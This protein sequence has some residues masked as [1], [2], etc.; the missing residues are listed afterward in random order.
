MNRTGTFRHFCK[1]MFCK[2]EVWSHSSNG[3][4]VGLNKS[5]LLHQKRFGW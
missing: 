4:Q 3:A 2:M 5:C 1:W